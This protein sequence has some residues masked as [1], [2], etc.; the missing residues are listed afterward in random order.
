VRTIQTLVFK[1]YECQHIF[2]GASSKGAP[3]KGW[4]G[5][6]IE[7]PIKKPPK[8]E[9]GMWESD[10]GNRYNGG[11][12]IFQCQPFALVMYGA[13]SMDMRTKDKTTHFG[14]AGLAPHGRLRIARLPEGCDAHKIFTDGGWI[15]PSLDDLSVRL[16]SLMQ[17]SNVT[18]SQLTE[19]ISTT[20]NA[21]C[22]GYG[23]HQFEFSET[24]DS[25][26]ILEP[27]HSVLNIAEAQL[28]LLRVQSK[29]NRYQQTLAMVNGAIAALQVDGKEITMSSIAAL[30]VNEANEE[31]SIVKE[32]IR[33]LKR[34]LGDDF[35]KILG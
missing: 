26:T 24:V 12:V 18:F 8:V 20:K 27:I 1:N 35:Q 29:E 14:F 23:I 33:G 2:A 16:V 31:A 6:V 11:R 30:L 10:K 3:F 22:D 21:I 9:F 4:G 19:Q 15:P 5:S 34:S 13:N 7:W 28:K 17:M 32:K 25:W